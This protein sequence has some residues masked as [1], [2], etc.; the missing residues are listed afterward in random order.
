[1]TSLPAE[2]VGLAGRGML[3]ENYFADITLFDANVIIDKANFEDPHQY[4][5]GIFYVLINGR[6][7]IDNGAFMDILPGKV[8][9]KTRTK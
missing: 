6:L 2:S 5:E 9:K 8:L 7:I 1:M 4:P 3:K